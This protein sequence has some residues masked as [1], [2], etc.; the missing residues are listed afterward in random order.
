MSVTDGATAGTREVFCR[1]CR[2]KA[3]VPR[4]E[5]RG[6]PY[7]W[8]YLTVNVPPWFN[9]AAASRPYRAVGLFCSADCLAASAEEIR[10]D[11][12]IHREA[13]EHE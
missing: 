7:G 11:E 13:Y 6:H 1:K 10:A 2:R 8:Y 4:E 3:R 12:E 5:A 9:S